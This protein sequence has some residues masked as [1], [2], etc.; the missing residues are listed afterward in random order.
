MPRSMGAHTGQRMNDGPAGRH[1]R[2]RVSVG[3]R[4]ASAAQVALRLAQL[5]G[6]TP[7][8]W[9]QHLSQDYHR[10]ARMNGVMRMMG[11]IDLL[12]EKMIPVELSLGPETVLPLR[13]ALLQAEIADSREQEADA[14][15]RHKLDDGTAT[16]ADAENL[17]KLIAVQSA[18][19]DVAM[20]ALHTWIEKKRREE[21]ATG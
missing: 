10:V 14:V 2:R 8:T 3:I 17:L 9:E 11:A 21:A 20:V 12:T 19:S 7:Q 18:R 1:S 6:S 15:F 16:V 4:P 13:D 5:F